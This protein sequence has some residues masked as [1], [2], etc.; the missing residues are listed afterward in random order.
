[1]TEFI[2]L[3]LLIGGVL[4]FHSARKYRKWPR[5]YSKKQAKFRDAWP[6]VSLRN[7]VQGTREETP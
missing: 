5:Y 1:M 3:Y 7:N 2:A 4:G 6:L